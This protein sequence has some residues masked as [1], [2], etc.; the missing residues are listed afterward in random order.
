MIAL[1]GASDENAGNGEHDTYH[2]GEDGEVEPGDFH[3]V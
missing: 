1:R 3:D 2:E